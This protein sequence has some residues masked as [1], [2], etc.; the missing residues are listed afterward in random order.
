MSRGAKMAAIAVAFVAGLLLLE[1]GARAVV[2]AS[3]ADEIVWYDASTQLRVEILDD[4][5]PVEMV[6]AGTSSAWQGL[7]PSVFVE[8]GAAESAFNV[9]LAGGVPAVTSPWLLEEVV[10]RVDPDTVV[11][12]LTSLDFSTAYGDTNQEAYEDA[13]E[14]RDGWLA[15]V[16]RAVSDVSELVGSRRLLRSPSQLWGQGQDEIQDD[17]S[18]AESI[19]GPAGERLDFTEDTTSERAAIMTARVRDY[20]IDASDVDLVRATV[21]E[22]LGEGRAVVLVE[23]PFPDRFV[24]LHPNGAADIAAA[25]VV[26]DEIGA[27][28]AVPVLRTTLTLTDDDFVDFSHMTADA[29]ARF[30]ADIAS[31]ITG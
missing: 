3:D 7:V 14:T 21:A 20:E 10:P 13:F 1:V 9:G 17:F 19:L 27:E 28:F 5:G 12:G 24:E 15:D 31:Q 25:N 29:A 6:M 26:I 23:I 11:W 16:D 8:A 4:L 18:E 2:S 30:S 22:L